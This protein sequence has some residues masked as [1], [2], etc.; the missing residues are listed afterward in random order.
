MRHHDKN[1]KLGREKRQR[2]ALIRSLAR[3]L[4]LS[5]GIVT[6]E[7]KAKTL[8]PFIE[9]LITTIKKG[10]LA[11]RRLV[12]EQL[13]DASGASK[14]MKELAERYEKRPGGYTR[15][16][17]LGRVGKRV[18]EMARIELVK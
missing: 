6:T 14:K 18:G 2:T 12:V 15:I 9:R 1:R 16:T 11:G 10:T 5:E 17:R 8:R 4:V 7:A 13:G 3:S